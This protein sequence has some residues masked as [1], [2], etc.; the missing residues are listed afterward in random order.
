L[1]PQPRAALRLPGAIVL[2]SRWDFSLAR[3]A[4]TIGERCGSP[5]PRQWLP[6]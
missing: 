5:N 1:C 3:S 2:S 6:I 4:R